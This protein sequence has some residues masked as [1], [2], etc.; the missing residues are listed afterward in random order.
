MDTSAWIEG[1]F[2]IAVTSQ[3][4]VAACRDLANLANLADTSELIES[5]PEL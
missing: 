3:P 5:S 4:H 1:S 2:Q